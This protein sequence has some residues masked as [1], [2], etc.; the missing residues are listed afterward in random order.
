MLNVVNKYWALSSV[1][2]NKCDKMKTCGRQGLIC[3]QEVHSVLRHVDNERQI[4]HALVFC[5]EMCLSFSRSHFRFLFREWDG[6]MGLK[7]AMV[8]SHNCVLLKLQCRQYCGGLPEEFACKRKKTV[9]EN[10]LVGNFLWLGSRGDECRSVYGPFLAP[11]VRLMSVFWGG[12]DFPGGAWVKKIFAN[13][14]DAR[15][16]GSIPGLGGSLEEEMATHSSILAWKVP[17]TEEPG[18]YSPCGHKESDTTEWLSA[19]R[20]RGG[21]A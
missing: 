16:M 21:F 9:T 17:W 6:G 12:V 18:G 15:N 13:A 11:V 19:Q 5:Y 1:I 10:K 4:S 3:S 14:G 20:A 2:L 7:V 8:L